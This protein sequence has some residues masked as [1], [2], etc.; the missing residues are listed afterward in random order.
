MQFTTAAETEQDKDVRMH[1]YK[2]FLSTY[3]Q[4][5][6]YI[7][8]V[9]LKLVSAIEKVTTYISYVPQFSSQS[10]RHFQTCVVCVCVCV[11]INNGRRYIWDF[12]YPIQPMLYR[13][14]GVSLKSDSERYYSQHVHTSHLILANFIITD[15]L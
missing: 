3:T 15:W 10:E 4:T 6:T 13:I 7:Q 11:C 14:K 5:H 1:T 8:Y 2:A 9:K 12:R